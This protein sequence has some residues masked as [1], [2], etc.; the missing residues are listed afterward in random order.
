MIA[1]RTFDLLVSLVGLVVLCIPGLLLAAVVKLASRGPVLF[2]QK[3][4]GRRGAPFTCVKFR[5]MRADADTAGSITVSSDP[6]TTRLGRAL[7]RLKLDELPQLVNVCLGRMSFVG[8]RPDVPG[9]A[10]RLTGDARRILDLRPGI[11]GPA[12]IYFRREEQILAQAGDARLYNDTVVWPRKVQLNLEYLDHRSLWK[13]IGYIL[14]TV[15]PWL[16]GWLKLV[17]DPPAR[18]EHVTEAPEWIRALSAVKTA[19]AAEGTAENAE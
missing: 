14:I 12:S 13:D 17:P 16:N 1:K 11:T 15:I 7:R 8:P 9:Y 18:P 4:I 2:T 10:D 19:E 3:R 6:R 5:T